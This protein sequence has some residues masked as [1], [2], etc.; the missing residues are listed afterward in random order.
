MNNMSTYNR[1]TDSFQNFMLTANV[2]AS[3]YSAKKIGDLAAS[4]QRANSQLSNHLSGVNSGLSNMPSLL[5]GVVNEIQNISCS[6]ADL[7]S[8]FSY[9][10]AMLSAKVQSLSNDT[11]MT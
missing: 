1:N 9:G 10:I 6:I 4:Q 5:N 11:N 7:G 3:A 2:A 8:Q